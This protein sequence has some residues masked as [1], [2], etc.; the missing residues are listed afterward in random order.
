MK[1]PLNRRSPRQH[2]NNTFWNQVF[3][4]T[5]LS[6]CTWLTL[7]HFLFA[8]TGLHYETPSR[9]CW[10][11]CRG[12]TAATC[13]SA[14]VCASMASCSLGPCGHKTVHKWVN[15][16]I[17]KTSPFNSGHVF[18]DKPLTCSNYSESSIQKTFWAASIM[19]PCWRVSPALA[20]RE[21]PDKR[22]QAAVEADRGGHT[23]DG[24]DP[25]G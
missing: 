7:T 3:S 17:I 13:G 14:A 18:S 24:Y 22:P 15:V 16:T 25:N 1:T 20:E 11:R 19:K 21:S 12:P 6:S 8:L 23:E 4:W 10:Q 9:W 2:V 5:Q